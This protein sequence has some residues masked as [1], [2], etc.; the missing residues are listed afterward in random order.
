VSEDTIRGA[1]ALADLLP[2]LV[3]DLP[4][5]LADVATE[6]REVSPEY[7][8]V[9]TQRD[10]EVVAAGVTAMRR[11]VA[12]ARTGG[13]P[14][15]A[16]TD[17]EAPVVQGLFESLGRRQW[18]AGFPLPT[19]LAAFQAGAR[20]AWRHVSAIALATGVPPAELA[21]LAGAVFSLVDQLSSASAAGY[22]A[23]QEEAGIAQQ[24]LRDELVRLLLS[25]RSDSAAVQLAARRAGWRLPD[26][27]TVVL[28][29]ADDEP[30]RAALS[31]LEPAGLRFRTAAGQGVVVPGPD[32]AD[33]RERLARL[34]AGCPAVIGPTVPLDSLPLSARIAGV[35]ADLRRTG[36]LRG[37]P[38]FV[39]DHI[40]ALI[41][42]RE[43]R[44]L[45]ALRRRRLAPLDAAAPAIRQALR[46][47][48]RA[49]LVHMGDNRR[50]AAELRVHPQTVRYRLG[51]LHELFGSEL[52][53]PGVRL[54]LLLALAWD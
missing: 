18:R 44:L 3:A 12:Q 51:R 45:E 16:G 14:P 25:D 50:V 46:E 5:L 21:A 22:L 54:E 49:W 39:D 43:P 36:L 48:L 6:L 41:V 29:G 28:A 2:A 32:A 10:T 4:A 30:S 33:R 17:P 37:T 1:D 38:V 23:E 26:T 19:L 20:V 35:A 31:R 42:H 15:P 7:A 11:L 47:T 34:L 52:D 13:R 8:E 9:L 40:G 27:A 53:D 24:R